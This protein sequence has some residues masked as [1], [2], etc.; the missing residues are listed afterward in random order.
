MLGCMLIPVLQMQC[1]A[2]QPRNNKTLI[3]GLARAKREALDNTYIYSL[4]KQNIMGSFSIDDGNGSENVS[5][6]MISRFFQSLSRLFQF[7]ERGK[8]RRIS[9]ELIS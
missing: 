2:D 7:A 8:C 9:L 1:M 4:F 6:K 3:I 5:F